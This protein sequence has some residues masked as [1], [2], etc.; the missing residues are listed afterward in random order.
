MTNAIDI[1][2]LLAAQHREQDELVEKIAK[3]TTRS[4]KAA[5]FREMADKLEAHATIEEELFYPAVLTKQTE[6]KLRES[7]EEHLSLRRLLADLLEL[8][9]MDERFVAKLEVLGEQNEHH[10]HH[11]EEEELFPIV[12]KMMSHDELVALGAEFLSRF[13]TLV[14]T[15]P[16][17]DVPSETDHAAPIEHV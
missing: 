17:K 11:E 14:G 1:L 9:P 3:A 16:R 5:L 2:Q 13:E 4:A 8:D 12:R 6:D 15:H 7:T 10:A